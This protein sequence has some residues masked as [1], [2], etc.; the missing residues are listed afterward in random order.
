LINDDFDNSNDLEYVETCDL[1]GG[2]HFEPELTVSGWNLVKCK[3][4]KLVFTS[5]RFK[6]E[7]L[8]KM[9]GTTYYEKAA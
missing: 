6:E 7:Y 9:Y 4:C 8:E 2:S 5:P 3:D 1:C